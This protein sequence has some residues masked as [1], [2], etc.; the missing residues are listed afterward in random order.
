[1][2]RAV[3]TLSGTTERST[4]SGDV[5]VERVGV[6]TQSDIGSSFAHAALPK[7]AATESS[8]AAW[9]D[10]FGCPGENR[11]GRSIPNGRWQ[12]L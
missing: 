12:K 6:N 5:T 4:L 1:M 11:P 2:N 8:G 10:S 9:R 3:L 7:V